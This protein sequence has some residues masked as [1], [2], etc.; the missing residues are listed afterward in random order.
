MFALAARHEVFTALQS[1]GSVR[2]ALDVLGAQEA[3]LLM[4]L[5]NMDDTSLDEAGVLS[6]LLGRAADRLARSL[7][8]QA[9]DTGDIE[10]LLPDVKYLRQWAIDLREPTADLT[11]LAPLADWVAMRNNG[12]PV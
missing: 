2:A 4:A 6:R 12:A 5:A 7:E 11:E 1:A 8:T 10:R 9:R 3:E